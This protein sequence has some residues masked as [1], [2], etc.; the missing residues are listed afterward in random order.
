M[1]MSTQAKWITTAI[2]AAAIAIIVA[3]C[4]GTGGGSGQK[5]NPED[6]FI[7]NSNASGRLILTI[8]PNEGDANK[9]DRI[10]LVA[11][12]TDRFG[13]PIPNILITFSSDIPD[14]QF[15]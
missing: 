6:Q 3:S 10:G 11:T 13:H 8:N 4:G 7:L 1:T 15:L 14:I 5:G 2:S 12:L 9:S